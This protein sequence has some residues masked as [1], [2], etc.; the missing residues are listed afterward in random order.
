MF[1]GMTERELREPWLSIV[2]IGEDGVAGLSAPARESIQSATLVFGGARHL[3]LAGSLIRGTP[4]PW[5]SPFERN[6]PEVLAHR[7]NPV[8]VLASGDPFMHGIGSLLSRHVSREE[9]VAYP[10]PSAFSLAAARLQWPLS[11]VSLLSL[12]GRPVD[13][14]RP[15]LQSGGRILALTSDERTPAALAELLV[16]NGFPRS[17]ITVLEALGGP[18]ER[19]RS[20]SAVAFSLAGINPLN[21]V[22]VEVVADPQARILPRS[23]GLPDE[24]FEHDGQITK[25]EIR[26]LTLAALAPCRGEHLWDVGA[27][28]GSIAIEWLLADPSL[29]AVAIEQRTDRA[30]RIRR[31]ATAFGVPDL[32]VVGASAPAAFDRLSLPDAI[33]IGGGATTPGVMAAARAALRPRGRLVVNAISLQ[34]EALLLN[35]HAQLGG[36]LLRVS[37]ARSGPLSADRS[38]WRPAMPLLQ[39]S[40]VNA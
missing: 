20:A 34:T 30:A 27:G 18:K 17:R 5:L 7:G 33:F 3:S 6:L 14:I 38:G 28:S 40:W 25:R 39:W 22:A 11:E 24:L 29:T 15:H 21:V 8:C 13:L 26:A 12:C 1:C 10:A 4:R 31:N 2:G 9:V 36:Q 23:P 32:Q 35:E 37:L 16:D 19:V